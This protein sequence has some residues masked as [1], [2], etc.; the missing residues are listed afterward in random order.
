MSYKYNEVIIVDVESTCWD[1]TEPPPPGEESEI[2]EIGIC[3]LERDSDIVNNLGIF[4]KPEVSTYNH[5]TRR[6]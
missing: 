6:Y 3:A 4:V 2:I 5:Y 1:S